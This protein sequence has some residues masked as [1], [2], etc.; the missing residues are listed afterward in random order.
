MVRLGIFIAF[1][2]TTW[3]AYTFAALPGRPD[4]RTVSSQVSAPPTA[5]AAL[6]ELLDGNARF[7][8]GELAHP[9]RDPDD[10]RRVSEKQRPKA[11]VLG[12]A[13]S[14][15]PPEILF[16]QGIGDL[17]V[18][19]VAG[20]NVAETQFALRGSVE[21]AVA[22]LHTPLAIVLGHTGCGA[23]KAALSHI[24]NSGDLPG[25]IA[26]LIDSLQPAVER[27][28]PRQGDP[29]ANLIRANVELTADRL[30]SLDPILAAATK[31][32]KLTVVGA[33]YDLKSGRIQIVSQEN[34]Q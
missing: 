10:V 25:A 33:I 14:R 15:V 30:R 18:V 16:D 23:M 7:V 5:E 6:R 20:N 28:K 17:F 32:G 1:A 9:R 11:I 12:C 4:D 31:T 27:A 2:A 19:R 13:D 29:L 34:R 8:N 26:Q 24:G 21:Y 22:E 3:L